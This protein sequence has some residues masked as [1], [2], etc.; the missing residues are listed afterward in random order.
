MVTELR[1][2]QWRIAQ[3]NR[4]ARLKTADAHYIQFLLD[5]ESYKFLTD[6]CRASGQTLESEIRKALQDHV[7]GL[8]SSNARNL[9]H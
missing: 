2:H 8:K 6:H 5:D 9:L 7:A 4:R 3:K 1:K